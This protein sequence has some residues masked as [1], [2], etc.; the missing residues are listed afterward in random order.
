MENKLILIEQ[1]TGERRR[2][3]L[4]AELDRRV[5]QDRREATEDAMRELRLNTARRNRY[6]AIKRAALDRAVTDWQARYREA[7]SAK[8]VRPLIR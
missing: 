4:Q 8:G 5:T 3:Q 1:R 2:V 7:C 6:L